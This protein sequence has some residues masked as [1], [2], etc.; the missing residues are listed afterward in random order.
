[1]NQYHKGLFYESQC[2]PYC[3]AKLVHR[4]EHLVCRYHKW[5]FP[6]ING[7]IVDYRMSAVVRNFDEQR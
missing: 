2:C 7:K 5:A 1:M 4:G 3:H 6:I